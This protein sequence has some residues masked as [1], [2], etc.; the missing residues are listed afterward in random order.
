MN[1]PRHAY[2]SC[3][4]KSFHSWDRLNFDTNSND[5]FSATV[6][7]FISSTTVL[8]PNGP[9]ASRFYNVFRLAIYLI[10]QIDPFL[11]YKTGWYIKVGRLMTN[12]F[13]WQPENAFLLDTLI[14]MS[15]TLEGR[16]AV[17]ALVLHLIFDEPNTVKF[18]SLQTI[19]MRCKLRFY[20]SYFRANKISIISFEGEPNI[21]T[22]KWFMPSNLGVC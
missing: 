6:H 5:V 15:L 22:M 21:R 12:N 3:K 13:R 10:E 17:L 11:L 20:C 9:N 4:L 18:I 8:C 7:H 16:G 14:I 2:V 19:A 1:V